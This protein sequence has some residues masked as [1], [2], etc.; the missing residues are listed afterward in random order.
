MK[1]AIAAM[2]APTAKLVVRSYGHG[3]SD[4][5]IVSCSRSGLWPYSDE[6]EQRKEGASQ[7][8]KHSHLQGR[9]RDNLN[10]RVQTAQNTKVFCR[11]CPWGRLQSG[12]S[13]LPPIGVSGWAVPTD[14]TTKGWSGS[15]CNISWS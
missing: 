6:R 4:D 10:D 1:G 9:A 11:G 15:C 14:A 5:P 13:G 7:Q 2:L 3:P 8:T 12:N